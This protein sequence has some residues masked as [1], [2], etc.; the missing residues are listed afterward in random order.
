[1][2]LGYG[3][4]LVVGELARRL[5]QD[6]HGAVV[7][8]TTFDETYLREG[9][10]IEKL[11]VQG[12]KNNRALPLYEWNASRAMKRIRAKLAD[13]DVIV[14]ATFPFYGARC[15]Y[16][17]PIVHYDFGNVPTSGFSLRGKANW[18]YLHLMETYLH[19]LRADAV[20]T[21]SQFLAQRFLPEAQHKLHVIHLGG[22]HY[23]S[24]MLQRGEEQNELRRRTRERLG[25][26]ESEIALGCCTRLHRRHAPYK[27]LSELIAVWKSLRAQG[28][29]VK[30]ALAGLGSPEDEAWLR[31][32]G[33]DPLLNLPPEEMPA[34]YSALDIYASPS[35]WE[36]FNLPLVE[37]AWFGVPAVAF[38][39]AAHP[40]TTAS[41]LAHS[42]EEFHSHLSLLAHDA[43]IRAR[44]G[45]EASQQAQQ[46]T[47][48]E[49]YRAFLEVLQETCKR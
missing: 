33:A 44:L 47:W 6:G 1:M 48:G 20:V 14:P 34:F 35:E 37:A 21:I 19:T 38:N 46:F 49:T 22:D 28:A 2:L 29:P 5:A 41:L 8:T 10:C 9:I 7:F 27:N 23:Y 32:E 40:E 43:R 39:V 42:V 25:I 45:R 16:A 18:Q 13:C 26:S 4:D 11:E 15:A 31:A 24:A 3:V 36:G 17:G 12:G 30:L